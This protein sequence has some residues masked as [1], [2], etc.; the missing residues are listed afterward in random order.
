[1]PLSRKLMTLAAAATAVFSFAS[2][3]PVPG[4]AAGGIAGGNVG[5]DISWPQCGKPVP[6]GYGFVVVGVTGGRPFTANPCF[7]GQWRWAM[8]TAPKTQVYINLEYGQ[9]SD[10]PLVCVDG[11]DLCMAYNF[12]Y[13]S[14]ADAF[15]F[16][17]NQTGGATRTG[18]VWWLDVETENVWSDNTDLN[19]FV[20]Q[21]ALDYMQRHEG[22]TTGIYSTRYQFGQI[23][24]GY[25]PPRTPNW[26]AGADSVDDW[27]MCHGRWS[28]WPGGDVWLFQYLNLEIDLD[29]NRAC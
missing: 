10:G 9:S 26:V 3:T 24:G 27:D 18:T 5:I 25:A 21:G 4:H 14:A 28:L 22:Q 2:S 23:A 16:A 15:G 8:H 7:A 29:Q 12:G 6:G 1:M 19:S 13:R 11:E 20:I 17:V